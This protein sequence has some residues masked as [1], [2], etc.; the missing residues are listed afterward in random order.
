MQPNNM[1]PGPS[2]VP[3]QAPIN[4]NLMPQKPSK[5]PIIGLVIAIVLLVIT[6]AFAFWAF[7]GRQNYKNNTDQ[8][9]Q[10]AVG[11]ALEEQKKELDAQFAE[12]EKSPFRSYIS[13]SQSGS[14]KIVYP[15]TWSAYVEEDESGAA[16][17]DGYWQPKYV[18]DK[19]GETN[20]YLRVEVV[21]TSYQSTLKKYEAAV[22][23]GELKASVYTP[24]Q[25]KGS[26]VGVRY[27]GEIDSGKNGAIVI[28]PLRDKV[29]K[30]WTESDAALNDFNKTVLK[31]L[32]FSP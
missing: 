26:V 7:T 16:G 24:E 4:P 17:I 30:V 10:K 5:G 8:I 21:P 6:L 1:Y 27:D 18:P 28:L 15:K 9:S 3:P 14:V 2:Q 32:T 11:A 29:L 13:P 25:L 22:E 31:N 12:Q 23:R 20:F 19:D